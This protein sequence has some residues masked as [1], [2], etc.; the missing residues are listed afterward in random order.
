MNKR[1]KTY[2]SLFSSSGVGCFGFK[3]ENFEC[4]VTN[5]IIERRLNVQKIN[6][7]IRNRIYLWRYSER[8]SKEKNI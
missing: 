3:E 1:K 4:V 8:R 5:E 2:I 6:M 7:Q